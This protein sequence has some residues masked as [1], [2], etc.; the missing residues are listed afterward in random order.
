MALKFNPFWLAAW[1]VF[2]AMSGRSAVPPTEAL[3]L[4]R[5]I[6][7]AVNNNPEVSAVQ[8]QSVAAAADVDAVRAQRLPKVSLVGGYSYATEDQRLYPATYNSEPGVFGSGVVDGAVVLK[9]PLYTGGKISS[10]IAASE[11]MKRAAAGDLSRSREIVA[12][13]VTSLFYSMLAQKEV[14]ASVE[15]AMTA[16]EEQRRTIQELVSLQKAARVDALRAE[17]RLAE[18]QEK[19]TKEYN[20]LTIQQWTLAALL[21]LEDGQDVQLSGSLELSD[22]PQCPDAN[23]CMKTALRNRN[24]YDAAQQRRAATGESVKSARSGFLPTLSLE[25]SYGLRWMSDVQDA[26][27]GSDDFED[28]GQIGLVAEWPLFSGGGTR[29]KVRRQTAVQQAALERERQLRLQIRTEVETALADISS[30]TERIDTTKTAVDAARE[31]FRI[32]QEK[33]ELG[34]GAMVD[35]LTAQASLIFAE[36]SYARARADL[37]ISDARRKLAV[38]G[39]L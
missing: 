29:A 1:L 6:E 35:V 2:G 4:D 7:M 34:K 25:S 26:S 39:I 23:L 24:D 19:R 14:I 11:L 38:G 31:S 18:L 17:V 8:W 10:E 22:P 20:T 9:I 37:A 21:G 32:I 36:T 12:F 15:S 30:A 3:T 33:Y 27:G 16:M 5:A 28:V 13:N